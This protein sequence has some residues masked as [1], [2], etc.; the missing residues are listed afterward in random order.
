MTTRHVG[1][2]GYDAAMGLDIVGPLDAFACANEIAAAAAPLYECSVLG[3]GGRLFTTESGLRVAPHGS[4]ERAPPLDTLIIPGGRGMRL[5]DHA[6]PLSSWLERRATG[7]RRIAS[8]CTGIYGLAP[9]GL[10]DGRRVTTHWRF[11]AD[12]AERY[13]A[14]RVEPNAIFIADGP[15]FTSAG[16]TAGI[17]LALALIEA[18]HGPALAMRVARELVVYLKRDG[19]QAQYSEPLRFQ[20]ET[21]DRLGEL[22]TWIGAHLTAD[23]SVEALASRA[24]LSPRQLTRR[25]RSAFALSPG[26]LVELLR[27]DEARL[28]LAGGRVSIERVAQS[29][30]FG[31][32]DVFRRAFERRFGVAPRV[33]RARFALPARREAAR[34]AAAGIARRAARRPAPGRQSGETR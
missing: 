3:I 1:I 2:V 32:A 29:V 18:D 24:C 20:S 16:V 25:F 14:L 31:S 11:A 15:F 30:G 19:G 23:L 10:L 9:T 21:R 12:L 28:R 26:E 22:V 33:Y 13:P 17:D 34:P 5:G 7:I 4:L 6:A 27:L 8:V